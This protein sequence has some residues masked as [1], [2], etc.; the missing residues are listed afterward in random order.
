M[1]G[2]LD[3]FPQAERLQFGPAGTGISFAMKEQV[4]LDGVVWLRRDALAEGY[5]DKKIAKLVRTGEWHRVRRGAYTSAS[6]G[7]PSA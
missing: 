3:G 1:L 6:C 5:N 2:R 4:P 7:G